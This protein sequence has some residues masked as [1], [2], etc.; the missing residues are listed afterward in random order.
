MNGNERAQ[1]RMNAAQYGTP[2]KSYPT[3]RLGRLHEPRSQ[4]PL[5]LDLKLAAHQDPLALGEDGKIR[6]NGCPS[7]KDL[8]GGPA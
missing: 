2:A 8:T 3:F 7:R 4:D 6:L 1:A 5:R